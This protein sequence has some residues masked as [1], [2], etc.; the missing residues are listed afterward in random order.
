MSPQITITA[1][2]SRRSLMSS[3]ISSYLNSPYYHKLSLMVGLNQEPNKAYTFHLLICLANLCLS[4]ISHFH[5]ACPLFAEGLLIWLITSSF[6]HLICSF[7]FHIFYN[8]EV[9][10]RSQLFWREHQGDSG[11]G[12]VLP[13]A[14]NREAQAVMLPLLHGPRTT[15]PI[16]QPLESA[17]WALPLPEWASLGDC[18]LRFLTPLE[19]VKCLFCDSVIRF[20]FSS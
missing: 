20:A 13:V 3:S 7:I 1:T 11:W 19:L 5:F 17:P 15:S 4:L 16:S 8:L 12:C 18:L 6:C 14:L 9:R 2:K 10:L